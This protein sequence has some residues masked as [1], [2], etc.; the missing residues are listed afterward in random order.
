MITA[1]LLA[2]GSSRRM[3][4]ENKLLL[5]FGKKKVVE[6]V[7]DHLLEVPDLEIIVVLGHEAK[8]VQQVIGKRSV[9][10]VFNENHLMGMT[11]SIQAGVRLANAQ[12]KGYLICLSDLPL[13]K[14]KTYNQIIQTFQKQLSDKSKTI[15][16]PTFQEKKGHPI[17]FASHYQ[18]AILAHQEMEGCKKIIQQNQEQ[19]Y[20]LKMNTPYIL[21][22]M[23][24]PSDYQKLQDDQPDDI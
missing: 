7:L 6:H 16:I 14:T 23:D 10:F 21:Q 19:L 15:V 2:A 17:L 3:G 18:Q 12:S 20:F 24:T 22:D 8:A 1:I 11:T 4:V 9:Q 5:P 13:I